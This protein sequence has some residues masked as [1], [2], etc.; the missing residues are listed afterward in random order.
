MFEIIKTKSFRMVFSFLVGLFIVII[1]KQ[2]CV[3]DDCYNY[4]I[5]DSKEISSNTYM[6]KDK[7]YQFTPEAVKT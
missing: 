6:L 5:P 1:F 2:R 7:C 4:T 3:G